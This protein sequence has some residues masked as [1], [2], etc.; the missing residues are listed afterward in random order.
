[1]LVVDSPDLVRRQAVPLG[2][3]SIPAIVVLA[4]MVVLLATAIVPPAVAALL[5]AGAMVLLRVVSVQQAYRG[6]SWT[7]VLLVAG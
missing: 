6:I 4:A 2:R 1:M 7:T 3:G 5:A